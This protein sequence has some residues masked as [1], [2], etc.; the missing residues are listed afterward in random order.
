MGR[1]SQQSEVVKVARW[2]KQVKI[3]QKPNFE[4]LEKFGFS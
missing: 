3:D 2:V 4:I 1:K